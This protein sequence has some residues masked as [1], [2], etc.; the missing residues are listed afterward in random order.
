MRAYKVF[1]IENGTVIDHIPAE[2]GPTLIN[3][4]GLHKSGSIVTMGT[5]F[6]SK[7]MGKKDVV[8]IENRELTPDEFNQVALIAPEATIN[9]IR[10]S[11]N[12]KKYTI[13]LPT[14]FEK[15][16]KCPNHKCI[17]NA[18]SCTTKFYSQ[19]KGKLLNLR[20]HYCE[21][22]FFA[23]EVKNNITRL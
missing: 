1:A 19:M 12:V 17:T 6:T 10:N 11:K 4:L 21:K 13:T 15:I 23:D 2:N 18:E 22:V 7:K 8:K 5:N 20:C 16:I 9:I 14:S 3:L